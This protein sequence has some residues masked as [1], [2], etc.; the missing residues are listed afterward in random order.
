MSGCVGLPKCG[1][2][3]L[4]AFAFALLLSATYAAAQATSSPKNEIYLGYSWLHP[5]GNVDWGTVP[6]VVVPGGDISFVHYFPN[7]RKLGVIVD[8]SVHSGKG[9]N[10]NLG[11]NV[12][13][14]LAGLQ[15][16]LHNSQLSPFV[17]VMAG[18]AYL[19]PDTLRSEWKPAIDVGGGLD[20]NIWKPVSIR[21]AQFDYIWTY[22]REN[23][24]THTSDNWNMIR[25]SAGLVFNL[26]YYNTVPV[27]A[28]CTAQ[29]NDVMEGEPIKVSVTGS[30]FNPK[31]TLTYGWTTTVASFRRPML[32]AQPSIQRAWLPAHTRPT[33][34]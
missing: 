15:Y 32:R 33:Q 22:Y 25:L 9:A 4:L 10:N 1:P 11:A 31:H 24:P 13:L 26:G 12:G 3:A 27:T 20:L 21:I 7:A 8:G 2:A 19:D 29:P 34:P 18:A 6:D 28:A 23:N 30:N 14:G 16:K 17:R 5:N